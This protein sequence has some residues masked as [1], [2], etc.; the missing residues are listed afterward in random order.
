MA[1]GLL[2]LAI[3][4]PGAGMID[5]GA[6]GMAR[7]MGGGA[8]GCGRQP[9]T[10]PRMAQAGRTR[11]RGWDWAPGR[12]GETAWRPFRQ[13]GEAG[14][15]RNGAGSHDVPRIGKRQHS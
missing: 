15:A 7:A 8:T 1:G 12:T 6:I 13:P 3:G 14:I 5:P 11:F 4:P 2:R 9:A 10:P